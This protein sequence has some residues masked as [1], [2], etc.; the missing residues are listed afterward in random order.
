M[1][2][3]QYSD[4]DCIAAVQL[5]AWMVGESPTDVTIDEYRGLGM[6]PSAS[7]V[8]NRFD[9]WTAVQAVAEE[10]PQN[11]PSH[12]PQYYESVAALRRAREL[13]GHPVTGLGYRDLDV[14]VEYV[15]LLKPFKTWTGAKIHAGVHTV[16][17]APY[18]GK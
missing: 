8:I 16:G 13:G 2:M 9:G 1:K 11:V 3:P 14:D 7:T 17:D 12:L 18:T 4:S 10:E 5:A 6:E 15:E